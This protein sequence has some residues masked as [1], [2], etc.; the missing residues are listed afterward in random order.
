MGKNI[1]ACLCIFSAACLTAVFS[2][3]PDKADLVKTGKIN[4]GE[5][6]PEA[7]GK[8]YPNE[9][10]SWLKTRDPRPA[11]KSVYKKGWDTDKIIYDKLSEYPFMAL[12]FKGMGF[13]I[14]YNE[15]RGHYYMRVDQDIIDQSRTKSGGVCLNC[16]TPYMDSLVKKH[17]KEFLKMP[18]KEAVAKIPAKHKNLG[19]TCIDCHRESDM[20]LRTNRSV[21]SDGISH[22]DKKEFTR[23]EKRILV[24][25]Q[26]HV[27]YN[28]PKGKNGETMGLVHPWKGSKWG[29]ISIENIIKFIKNDPKYLEWKQAVTGFKLGFLRHPEFE[30][31]T[32]QS[33]HFKGGL[34]C[35]DCHMPYRRVG[36]AKISDHNL[37]SPL[38]DDL[39]ACI[40]C[41]PEKTEELRSQV[42]AI[43]DRTVSLLL[44]AG[45]SAATAAKLFE[46]ANKNRDKDFDRGLYE[47]AKD[48]YLEAMYR[49]IFMG[50]ENSLGFHNPSEAGRILGDSIAFSSKSESLLRQCLAGA[51]IKVQEVVPLEAGKYLKDRGE[52]K[53]NFIKGQEFRDPFAV[54][55][56]LIPRKKIGL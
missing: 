45:Y 39:R 46:I 3:A 54:Q 56:K 8:V 23:Q 25:A 15:P 18:W 9:Y 19:A 34:A 52:K 5:Y 38:K 33:V 43:Q 50:A 36:S 7:W 16:K 17:G 12:I 32:R 14:E 48:F 22:L 24:C 11:G 20:D 53:L 10:E 55:E 1:A 6:D 47:K 26:C 29:D 51:G 2:C 35:A 28:I 13:G 37:M 42:L 30:F 31:F 4:T 41:H 49:L 44:R 27:T 40:K 21:F